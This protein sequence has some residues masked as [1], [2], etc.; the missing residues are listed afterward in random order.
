MAKTGKVDLKIKFTDSP[1]AD[2]P[3]MPSVNVQAQ[4]KT[5]MALENTAVNI[6]PES[7]YM[8]SAFTYPGSPAI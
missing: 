8:G 1:N 6:Q 2:P 7:N 5:G 4:G 3:R